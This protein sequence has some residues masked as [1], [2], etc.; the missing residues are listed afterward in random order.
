[1]KNKQIAKEKLRKE[2]SLIKNKLSKEELDFRSEEVLSVVEI[3]GVFQNAESIFIYNSLKDEVNTSNFI[4]KW[5]DKKKFYLPVVKENDLVFREYTTFTQLSR[6]TL[7]ILEPQSEDL[8]NYKT[9]DLIIVPGVAF[10]RKM[11]RLGR[12]KGYY[13]RFLKTIAAPKM[14]I[15][16]DFQLF[17]QI[18]SDD[19]DIKMDYIVSENDLI[20]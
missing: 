14:G 13:D 5:I 17:D 10:D 7:G 3:T 18:P 12:G 6:S 19:L 4:Q 8:V 16:F 1:M 2:V 15:C 9:I 20:W 11:N